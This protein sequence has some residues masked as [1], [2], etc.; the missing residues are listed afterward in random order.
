MWARAL[1]LQSLCPYEGCCSSSLRGNPSHRR[2]GLRL[3]YM[4]YPIET[5]ILGLSR[6]TFR[7][8]LR[9][10]GRPRGSRRLNAINVSSEVLLHQAQAVGGRVPVSFSSTQKG[11]ALH[12][13]GSTEE[14]TKG[15][16]KYPRNGMA[17]R[18]CSEHRFRGLQGR[19]WPKINKCQTIKPVWGIPHC[20]LDAKL[21]CCYSQ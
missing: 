15:E 11:L 13:A 12:F 5:S 10:D 6:H 14:V 2:Y 9:M 21:K 16:V 3:F 4:L 18:L 1:V 8:S 19:S 20:K 17:R 7:D